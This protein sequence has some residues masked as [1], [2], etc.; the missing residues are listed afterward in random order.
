MNQSKDKKQAVHKENLKKTPSDNQSIKS[1]FTK[2][3]A[4]SEVKVKSDENV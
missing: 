3:L 1:F 2:N 4:Q